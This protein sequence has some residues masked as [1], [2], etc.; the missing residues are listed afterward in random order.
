MKKIYYDRK[1]RKNRAITLANNPYC[2]RCGV[3]TRA[4]GNG[5]ADHIVSLNLG[6]SNE[7]SNLQTMCTTCNYGLGDKTK[8]RN[9]KRKTR[10]NTKWLKI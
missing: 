6:G 8:R 10:I 4:L 5:T 1:Y 9:N 3:D 7:L 2:V